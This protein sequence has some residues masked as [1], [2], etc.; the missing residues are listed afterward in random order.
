MSKSCLKQDLFLILLLSLLVSCSSNTQSS[1]N[2]ARSTPSVTDSL[3]S[4]IGT[5]QF[6]PGITLEDTTL[7]YPWVNNDLTAVNRVKSLI[8]NAIPYEN[9]HIMAWGVDDPWPSRS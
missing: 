1:L 8:K 5:S 3:P 4:P 9:T 7:N 2:I 6:S